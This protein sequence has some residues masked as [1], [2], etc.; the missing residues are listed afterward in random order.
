MYQ[1]A[2]TDKEIDE[3]L[4]VA[5]EHINDGTVAWPGMS[6]EQ[7]VQNALDW[8]LGNNDDPPMDDE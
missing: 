6:Y 2:R 5:S 1:L 8:V 3:Q 7:G 4:N